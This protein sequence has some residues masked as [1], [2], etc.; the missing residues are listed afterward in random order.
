MSFTWKP[1]AEE[2]TILQILLFQALIWNC[3][4][5]YSEMAY[6]IL[7]QNNCF[8]FLEIGYPR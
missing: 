7:S 8:E 2:Y 4:F 5:G 3:I 6:K 1:L